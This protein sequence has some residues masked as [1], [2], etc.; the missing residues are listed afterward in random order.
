M[1]LIAVDKDKERAKKEGEETKKL[2]KEIKIENY[3]A[4]KKFLEIAE[5]L[6]E[7]KITRAQKIKYEKYFRGIQRR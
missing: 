7:G 2:I 4:G 6:I 3:P 5:G 1:G